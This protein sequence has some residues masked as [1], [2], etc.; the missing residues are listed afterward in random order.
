MKKKFLILFV[1]AGN[2]CRSPLA[3][4]IMKEE[5]KRHRL[6]GIRVSSAGVSA[7]EGARASE[8]ARKTARN[9]GLSLARFRSKPLT[10]RR[11]AL[12]D[13][14]LT[15]ED[16]HKKRIT[17]EYPSYSEKVYLLSEYSGSGRGGIEDP[18][19]RSEDGYMECAMILK[20]EIRRVIGKLKRKFINSRRRK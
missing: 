19:G 7:I 17:E 4:I 18:A 8:N 14:V 9:L 12:A 5:I 3:E 2:T 16:S 11:L 15:M 1:C 13:L 20:D 6:S 10:R